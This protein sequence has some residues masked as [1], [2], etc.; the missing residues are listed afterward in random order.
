MK[1][2]LIK[3]RGVEGTVHVDS[4][5]SAKMLVR[6]CGAVPTDTRWFDGPPPTV[7]F[8][9][10]VSDLEKAY[11][12]LREEALSAMFWRKDAQPI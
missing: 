6:R 7:Y 10:H 2:H 3:Y 5:A 11:T 12:A 9:L 1:T 4:A 8:A